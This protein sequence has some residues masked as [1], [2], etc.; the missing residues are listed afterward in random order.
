[1]RFHSPRHS[2][3]VFL[4]LVRVRFVC[5][6]FSIHIF[7]LF[8]CFMD[9]TPSSGQSPT[10]PASSLVRAHIFRRF[11]LF[12][13]LDRLRLLSF[14]L[15]FCISLFLSIVECQCR[16]PQSIEGGAV[17]TKKDIVAMSPFVQLYHLTRHSLL[18]LLVVG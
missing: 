2:L 6:A 12:K 13:E 17:T 11:S 16:S 8:V 10:A 5:A 3:I 4:S 1:M 15:S 9:A 14:F 18:H 7:Q